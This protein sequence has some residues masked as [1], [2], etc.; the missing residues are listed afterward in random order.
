MPFHSQIRQ[1]EILDE[2]LFL[3]FREGTFVEVGALY[4]IRFSNTLFFEE[5]PGWR[6]VCV[7]PEPRNYALLCANR[8]NTVNFQFAVSDSDGKAT[9]IRARGGGL[10]GLEGKA[11]IRRIER[12]GRYEVRIEVNC[13]PLSSMLSEASVTEV[14]YLSVDVEGA[15]PQVLG[16]LDF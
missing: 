12:E 14:Y 13:R 4:G 11:D 16:D 2:H 3:G 1:D 5:E 9:F 6:G 10:G 15:E 8:P 7:E